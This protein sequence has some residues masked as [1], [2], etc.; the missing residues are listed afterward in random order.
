[1]GGDAPRRGAG[2]AADL[3]QRRLQEWHNR[4][5]RFLPDSELSLLNADPRRTVVVSPLMVRLAE[6][7]V[8]AAMCTD[9][10][11]DGTLLDEIEDCGYVRDLRRPLPLELALALAPRRASAAGRP[12]SRWRL[13]DVDARASSVTRP[14][15]VKLDSGGLAKGLFADALAE[16]LSAHDSFAINC[17]GDARDRRLQPRGAAGP[18]AEPV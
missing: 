16:A 7:V 10:L 15:G 18:R 6:A 3:A 8:L 2:D 4:F 9:G 13:L 17:A 5:S 11:V 1:M 12:G 14:R